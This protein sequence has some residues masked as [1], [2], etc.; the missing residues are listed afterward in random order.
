MG[1]SRT[2]EQTTFWEEVEGELLNISFINDQEE[3]S[4]KR[5]FPE[6][7]RY[8]VVEA[9]P[10]NQ[11][12]KYVYGDNAWQLIEEKL[13]VIGEESDPIR[14]LVEK[15]WMRVLLLIIQGFN[16]LIIRLSYSCADLMVTILQ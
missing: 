15:V 2:E 16:H 11:G 6:Q 4:I 8:S 14:V 5:V 1:E 10:E 12:E 9:G 7:L 13:E 3:N